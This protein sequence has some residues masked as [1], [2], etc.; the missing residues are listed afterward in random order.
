MENFIR[1][2]AKKVESQ[3][4]FSACKEISSLQL[5]ENRTDLTKIQQI[6]LSYLFFYSNIFTDIALKKVNENVLNYEIDEDAYNYYV[7]NKKEDDNSN[8]NTN[9][10]NS[11]KLV[12]K[13]NK[14]K[15]NKS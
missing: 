14:K 9:D 8:T 11:I 13:Q 2:L 5:F 10:P 6:Y 3:N 15:R 7:K 1:K 4:V 12:F